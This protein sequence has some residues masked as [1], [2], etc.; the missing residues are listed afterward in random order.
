[1]LACEPLHRFVLRWRV[2]PK[3]SP[4]EVEVRF[5]PEN[6]GTRVDL[7][8]RGWDDPEG[9]ANY[10]TGWDK[11]LGDYAGSFTSE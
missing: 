7:E 8:H 5:K 11:V 4:S 2:N 3:R 1:M 10:D 9:R 6:G